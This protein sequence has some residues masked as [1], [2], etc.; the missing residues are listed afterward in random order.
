[1]RRTKEQVSAEEERY[2]DTIRS[3]QNSVEQIALSLQEEKRN[4]D[5]AIKAVEVAI[6]NHERFKNLSREGLADSLDVTQSLTEL[7]EARTSLVTTR[8]GYM[9]LYAQIRHVLGTI[10]LDESVYSSM[11]WLSA[12]DLSSNQ[13]VK[14][15]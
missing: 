3:V 14:N 7:V 6:E 4:L 11:N 10:P 5:I 9:S 8:Y 15:Q 2:E 12:I 1:M 13:E